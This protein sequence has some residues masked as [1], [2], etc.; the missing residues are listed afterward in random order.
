M[1]LKPQRLKAL[2]TYGRSSNPSAELPDDSLTGEPGSV[3][4]TL[5]FLVGVAPQDLLVGLSK[6]PMKTHD[7]HE[8]VWLN[9]I[10]GLIESCR[11]K[12]SVNKA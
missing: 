12:K 7:H 3:R 2:E 9:S 1:A 4:L 6:T 10:V 8:N 11:T 5:H